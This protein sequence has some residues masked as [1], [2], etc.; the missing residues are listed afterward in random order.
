MSVPSAELADDTATPPLSILTEV[1]HDDAQLLEL[2]LCL[3][4]T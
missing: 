3:C 1:L 4:A 2:N